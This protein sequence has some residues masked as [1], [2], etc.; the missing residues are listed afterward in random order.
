MPCKRCRAAARHRA[1]AARA[2]GP[3]VSSDGHEQRP[4][5]AADHAAEALRHRP[6]ALQRGP[7]EGRTAKLNPTHPRGPRRGFR[8]PAKALECGREVTLQQGLVSQHI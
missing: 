3:H 7:R 8:H 6:R 1:A 5:R 4:G 2:G